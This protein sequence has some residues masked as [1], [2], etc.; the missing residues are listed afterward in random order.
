MPCRLLIGVAIMLLGPAAFG[1]EWDSRLE[2]VAQRTDVA[3]VRS[4]MIQ[5]ADVNGVEADRS[6]ALHWAVVHDNLELTNQ[7]LDVWV[8]FDDNPG[9]VVLAGDWQRPLSPCGRDDP[10]TNVS[11]AGMSG[12]S[13][14]AIAADANQP[15]ACWIWM[16]SDNLWLVTENALTVAKGFLR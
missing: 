10:P 9:P 4:L 1:A 11:I 14:G 16:V 5:H 6:T 15:R 8:E 3:A 7:M 13:V 12:L 2:D